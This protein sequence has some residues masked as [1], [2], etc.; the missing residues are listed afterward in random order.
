MRNYPPF[1]DRSR[2]VRGEHGYEPRESAESGAALWVA[3]VMVVL[4]LAALLVFN[5]DKLDNGGA[6]FIIS[7]ADHTVAVPATGL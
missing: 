6:P 1:S 4:S 7:P 3:A 2:R 5:H